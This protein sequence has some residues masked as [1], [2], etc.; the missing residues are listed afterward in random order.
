MQMQSALDT[1]SCSHTLSTNTSNLWDRY[2]TPETATVNCIWKNGTDKN[3]GQLTSA[4][5]LELQ[6]CSTQCTPYSCYCYCCSSVNYRSCYSNPDICYSADLSINFDNRDGRNVQAIYNKEEGT[7]LAAAQDFIMNQ[8]IVGHTYPCYYDTRDGVSILWSIAYNVGYWVG[9]CV[10]ALIVFIIIVVLSHPLLATMSN[11][12]PEWYFQTSF[13]W[14]WIGVLIPFLL[15]LPLYLLAAI[16][17]E[18]RAALLVLIFQF[19]TIGLM[20][21]VYCRWDEYVFS[22]Y[23]LI[24]YSLIGWVTPFVL[25]YISTSGALLA[26]WLG[27]AAFLSAVAYFTWQR[28]REQHIRDNPL[29]PQQQVLQVQPI[30]MIATVAQYPPIVYQI[31]QNEPP[32]Y[33]ADPTIVEQPPSYFSASVPSAPQY[34][35]R[36]TSWTEPHKQ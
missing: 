24:V 15:F 2:I 4:A 19:A 11:S 6:S 5:K 30:Q 35:P 12:V 26:S 13:V 36:A 32:T 23:I 3:P 34:Y 27:G 20:P 31:N 33:S 10:F 9:T 8:Y 7:N 18:G 22:A 16:P 25:W 1:H 14:L 17:Q 21:Y 28:I 29:P